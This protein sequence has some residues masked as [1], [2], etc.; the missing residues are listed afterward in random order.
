[1][2][3]VAAI[4]I[5]II[6]LALLSCSYSQI[7]EEG[8]VNYYIY[9]YL[10]FRLSEDRTYYKVSVV[11]GAAVSSLSIPGYYHTDYGT[12][13][14]R[15]FTGFE[16]QEDAAAL[17][18]IILDTNVAAI[19]EGA[20]RNSSKLEVIKT[21]GASESP[22]WAHLSSIDKEGFHFE[23]WKAGSQFV[24]NGMAI[25]P[26]YPDAVPVFTELKHHA[27]VEA[28]CTEQG[29]IEYWECPVCNKA[30][31]DSFAHNQVNLSD[32][33]I[34]PRGHYYPLMH[35]DAVEPTCQSA[36]SIE[37]WM[38]AE[39]ET[40]FID[41]EGNESISDVI[42]PIVDHHEHDGVIHSNETH[43][44]YQCRWCGTDIDSDEHVWGDWI[45]D[46]PSSLY[47]KG[48][49][50]HV[51]A[52]CDRTEYR[53]IPEHDHIEGRILEEHG[54]TCTEGGY[55]I[56]ECGNP[57]CGEKVRFEVS[58][59]LGHTGYYVDYQEPTCQSLGVKRHFHC[60]RCNLD[61]LNSSSIEPLDDVSIPKKPHTL[62][63][64]WTVEEGIHYHICTSCLIFR[65]DEGNHV[66][67][68]ER[69]DN[70]YLVSSST[71]QH[72]NTYLK[73]CICGK[74]GTETFES[75]VVGSHD[76]SAFSAVD[77]QYH[78]RVCI[79]CGEVLAGSMEVHDF[80][81]SGNGRV[82]T[83]CSYEVPDVDG[84]FSVVI[85]DSTPQGHIE[86]ESISGSIY[87]FAF[88]NDKPSSPPLVLEWYLEEELAKRTDFEAG[89]IYFS[90]NAPYPMTYSVMCRYINDSGAGSDTIT[91]RGGNGT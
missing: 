91:V 79:W 3:R 35:F 9:P 22:K 31:T 80:I 36:G 14:V 24:V 33:G 90:F 30:F 57:E 55:Y 52:V 75:G 71:C 67:D 7:G 47:K 51:C 40:F 4:L 6:L 86:V 27:R 69:T 70:D 60:T 10:K 63:A 11:D 85:G 64:R 18:R 39:C 65:S 29:N 58:P 54:A 21:T 89:D 1:M 49:K 17:E 78:Q 82:C 23:G 42:L 83:K 2:R 44:Y 81:H 59:P 28:S 87:T 19:K 46:I 32:T 15:E 26:E 76:Y 43:H 73:S 50:H 45:I 41:A 84:G 61:F 5:S 20:L 53:D 34:P 62:D 13:P 48:K 8:N 25:D 38:C 88:Y 16:N 68:N 77:G 37:Y 66:Y 72:A 56:E 12:M 74:A